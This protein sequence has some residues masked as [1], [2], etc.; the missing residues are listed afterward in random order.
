MDEKAAKA[1]DR[2]HKIHNVG[3]VLARQVIDIRT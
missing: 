2:N 1:R 3:T